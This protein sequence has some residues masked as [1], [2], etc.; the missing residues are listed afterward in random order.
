LK[1]DRQGPEDLH[2]RAR[3]IF[4]EA[5]GRSGLDRERYLRSTCGGDRI[6]HDEVESLL[7]FDADG[8]F[9]DRPAVGDDFA[10]PEMEAFHDELLP[11]AAQVGTAEES[12]PTRIGRYS[13]LEELGRGGAGVVYLAEQELTQRRVA[14]KVLRARSQSPLYLELFEREARILGLLKHTGIAQV[15]EAGTAELGTG[16]QMFFAIE[17]VEGPT[18]TE[19]ARREGLSTVDRLALLARVCDAVH[20]AHGRGVLHRDLKPDNVL[21]DENGSPKVLDFGVARFNQE[22]Q[23]SSTSDPERGQLVGTPA[24]MSPEQ[25]EGRDEDVDVRSDVYALGVLAHELL[26]GSS[27]RRDADDTAD[28]AWRPTATGLDGDIDAILSATLAPTPDDRYSSAAELAIDLRRYL[29]HEPIQVRRQTAGYLLRKF[30]QRRRALA[31]AIFGT[32][33]VLVA[34]V[35]ISSLLM[36]EAQRT[37]RSQMKLTEFMREI[38]T[39]PSPTRS[40][41]DV[42]V[43]EVLANSDEIIRRRLEQEPAIEA[44]VR[45]MLGVLYRQLGDTKNAERHLRNALELSRR[46]HGEQAKDTLLAKSQLASLLVVHFEELDEAELLLGDVLEFASESPDWDPRSTARVISLSASIQRVREQYD[47]AVIS[48]E[49]AEALANAA[50]PPDENL[51]LSLRTFRARALSEGGRMAEAESLVRTALIAMEGRLEVTN[52]QRLITEVTLGMVLLRAAQQDGELE[53]LE[54][55]EAVLRHAIEE[56]VEGL[57]Q[58]HPGTLLARQLLSEVLEETGHLDQAIAVQQEALG[59]Y[60]GTQGADRPDAE[61]ALCRLEE[62]LIDSGDS[63]RARQVRADFELRRRH[64]SD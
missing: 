42:T 20:H 52:R 51:I 55:A 43:L 37:A 54:E 28:S 58:S 45:L 49:K 22:E 18:I 7:A 6:L 33:A 13:V 34:G 5:R 47:A 56:R 16:P 62:L 38:L 31:S 36:L 32:F 50:S 21:V 26:T 23:T 17:L 57:G 40:G 44:N 12:P 64:E 24:Y 15:Y 19:H 4:L 39:S 10:V 3:E 46:V 25:R 9:L 27:P 41:A 14:I 53:R 61:E 8:S 2:H 48:Y 30:I 59:Y 1:G 60:V 29:A 11:C 35:I 63:E